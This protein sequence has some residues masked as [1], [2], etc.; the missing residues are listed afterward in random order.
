MNNNR[1]FYVYALKLLTIY[2]V[3]DYGTTFFIGIS[4]PGG[5]YYFEWLDTYFNYVTWLR[6]TI[7]YGSKILMSLLGFETILE[8]A[9]VIRI[10]NGSAVQ[11]VYSCLGYGVLSFWTAFVVANKGS[12]LFKL[13]WIALGFSLIIFSN[14][15]RICTLLIANQKQ[16]YKPFSLDHH[17]TYNIISYVLI[18]ILMFIYLKYQNKK[19]G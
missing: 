19:A 7:L 8:N 14:I 18:I 6:N 3:L 13:K 2:A 16:W 15:I 5:K 17:T 12:K 9:Y 4:S 10:V 11:L 1:S